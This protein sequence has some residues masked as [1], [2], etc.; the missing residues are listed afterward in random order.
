MYL[1]YIARGDVVWI[2]LVHDWAQMRGF[3][4]VVVDYGGHRRWKIC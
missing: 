4:K 2:Y 3:L 1:K